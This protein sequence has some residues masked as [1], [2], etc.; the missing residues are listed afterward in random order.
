M[1]KITVLPGDGIGPE[2][3]DAVKKIISAT[4]IEIEWEEVNAG[5]SVMEKYGTPLPDNVL[6]SIKKNKI[7][8]K[9]PITTPIGKG[10]RSVNV[11]LRKVLNLYANVR[12]A[13][14]WEGI[15][16][17]YDNID[18]VTV[19][20]NT[21]GLYSG[22]EHYVGKNAAETIKIITREATE[23]IAEYAFNYALNN[24]RK[25]IT[26]VHKANIQK[27]TDGLFL[28]VCREVS[29]KYPQI[30]CEDKIIDNMCMQ[31]VQYPEKY[32]VLLCPNFYGDIIS[33]LCSGLV[34]GLG[35][36]PGANIGSEGAVFEALHGSAP[37]IAGKNI[38]NPSALLLSA[39]MMLEYI[40]EKEKALKIEKAL[41]LVIKEGKV[42]TRDI[43]GTAT[44]TE[45]TEE[46]IKVINK[47]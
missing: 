11:E 7:A 15:K 32:D 43:G 46:I 16:G 30:E 17:R 10:F 21:E 41:K 12:P 22:V 23:N 34:G 20:E 14:T 29:K 31:L 19:R 28:D 25:K 39:V 2:I 37:D 3:T 4:G 5:I 6:E 40:G 38:A 36:A 42:V 8:L 13:K 27:Y 44:T 47:I 9:A 45:F 35:M 24:G 33:D 26:I 18:I 1:Y